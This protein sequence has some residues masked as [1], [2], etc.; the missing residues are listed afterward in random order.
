MPSWVPV[1]WRFFFVTPPSSRFVSFISH[2]F[3]HPR[4]WGCRRNR[5]G[6][7][8]AGSGAAREK[9]MDNKD[10]DN[11]D[12]DDEFWEL[13][14]WPIRGRGQ[15]VRILFADA[16]I[17]YK[18]NNNPQALSAAFDGGIDGSFPCFAPPII[19]KGNTLLA[20]TDVIVRY[21]SKELNLCPKNP[22]DEAHAS[23]IMGNIQ[24]FLSELGKHK[25]DKK[26]DLLKFLQG[27]FELWLSTFEKPLSL[28]KDQ[29]YYF[30][31]ACSF[32]DLSL[33]VCMR[34]VE[35]TLGKYYGDY[36][37][38][39]HAILHAHYKNIGQRKG[40]EG[41]YNKDDEKSKD[42][43][44]EKEHQENKKLKDEIMENKDQGEDKNRRNNSRPRG[45]DQEEY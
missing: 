14:Y 13:Y 32:A 22:L 16:G 40:V 4:V 9:T 34:Q 8:H 7:P 38:K 30:G 25:Q 12:D 26:E 39:K 19:R 17:K 33:H 31:D 23:Q 21:L 29:K 44:I 35:F 18:E 43:L 27:R 20:Q 5:S 10:K 45:K 24:D 15:F 41:L 11:D 3:F 2:A 1:A 42:Q 37:E 36:V 28:K 6:S